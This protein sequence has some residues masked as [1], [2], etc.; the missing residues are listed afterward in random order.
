LF[1]RAEITYSLG[2][3]TE[4]LQQYARFVK[5]HG[6][7]ARVFDAELGIG[8]VYFELK[9][10]ARAA[11]SF[12]RLLKKYKKPAEQARAAL[13]LGACQYNLRDLDG[14]RDIFGHHQ[15]ISDARRAYLRGVLPTRVA[16]VQ[17][18]QF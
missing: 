13:A 11:D 6:D 3:F 12:R 14:A 4:A 7:H 2:K 10:Y 16:R 17:K 18:K 8:W 15:R 1:L 9:Q 5:R